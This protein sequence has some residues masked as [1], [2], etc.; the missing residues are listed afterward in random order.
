MNIEDETYN[1]LITAICPVGTDNRG[2]IFDSE[3]NAIEKALNT[4]LIINKA[5]AKYPQ[6]TI[7]TNV[8]WKDFPK[9]EMEM[10]IDIMDIDRSEI[11]KW[12]I[13]K[14]DINTVA[15]SIC[16]SIKEYIEKE[17]GYEAV[18]NIEDVHEVPPTSKKPK[19]NKTKK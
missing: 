11:I 5:L 16:K 10:L 1:F 4:E 9:R 2:F 15:E 13:D 8:K 19:T 14:M 6:P 7:L 17:M 3:N 12:Y 18:E